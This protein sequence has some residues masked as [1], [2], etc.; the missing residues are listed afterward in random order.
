LENRATKVKSLQELAKKCRLNCFD[1]LE[2]SG[3]GH[4]GGSMSVIDILVALYFDIAK[5]NPKDPNWPDRDRI[6]LSKSHGCEGLYAV[7]GEA[8]FF[9]KEMFKTYG[10]YGSPLQGHA[11]AW[12]V[13]GVEYSGGSLGQGLSFGIGVALGDALKRGA[14][15][16]GAPVTTPRFY[17]YCIM[18]DGECHEGQVWEAAMSAAHYKLDNLVAVIDYNKFCTVGPTNEVL[19]LEPFADKWRAFGWDVIEVKG[20]DF[21]ELIDGF[22]LTKSLAGNGKPK[23]VIAHTVKGS[24]VPLWEETHSHNAAG[25]VLMK[26]IEQGRKLWS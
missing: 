2:S 23:C 8:G 1:V 14:D 6:I 12:A 20:H 7:L 5:V 22:N 3:V 10:T 11:E 21:D 4:N 15:L 24:G 18:G 17:V 19:G 26:G 16:K 25:D 9:P 13:P